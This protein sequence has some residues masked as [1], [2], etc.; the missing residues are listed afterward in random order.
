MSNLSDKEKERYIRQ[1]EQKLM[2]A[3]SKPYYEFWKLMIKVGQAGGGVI[4]QQENLNFQLQQL[5]NLITKRM[6]YF[7]YQTY[8]TES[9]QLLGFFDP[10]KVYNGMYVYGKYIRQNKG[11]LNALVVTKMAGDTV[12]QSQEQFVRPQTMIG[13]NAYD[14]KEIYELYR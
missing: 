11:V 5:T 14:Q 9:G 4:R 13:K 8:D 7:K 1:Y 3:M 10:Q 2:L 12:L 6:L